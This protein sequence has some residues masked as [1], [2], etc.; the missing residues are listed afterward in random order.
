VSAICRAGSRRPTTTSIRRARRCS[1][2]ANC[3][4]T[5]EGCFHSGR[6]HCFS[7]GRGPARQPPGSPPRPGP[8]FTSDLP[9]SEALPI[10]VVCFDRAYYELYGDRLIQTSRGRAN[11]HLH[12]INPGDVALRS[13]PNVRYSVEETPTATKGYF[14]TARFLILRCL[15]RHY[16]QPLLTSDADAQFEG[17]PQDLFDRAR[18]LDVLMNAA[19][20][21]QSPRRYLAAVPWR[22]VTA[23][24][25][26]ANPTPGAEAFLTIYEQLYDGLVSSDPGGPHWWID[27][28]LL[29]VTSDLISL[30]GRNVAFRQKWLFRNAHLKQ[31]KLGPAITRHPP[32]DD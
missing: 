27:Q 11:L 29:C 24:L 1:G 10:V 22:R 6:W 5:T 19:T 12:I 15:L 3:A 25:F 21:P 28:A 8:T 2:K 13:S 26:V 17:S 18:K 16:G 20:R 7:H 9:F 23:Q 30:E 4:T 31:G 32:A 14:A